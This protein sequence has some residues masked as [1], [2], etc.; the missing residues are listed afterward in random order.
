MSDETIAEVEEPE[1]TETAVDDAVPEKMISASRVE[2]LV[3][4]AKL[5]GRDAMQNEI[6]AVRQQNEELKAQQDQLRNSAQA[7][8]P[9][10]P[11]AIRKQVYDDLVNNL[12]LQQE[13]QK[14]AQMQAEA[15]K[16]SQEYHSRMAT[17]KD[18]F[19][20][21]NDVMAD[22]DPTAFPQLVYLATQ[23]ENT[24]QIMYELSKNPQKLAALAVLSE[25]DPR[26]AKAMMGK[27]SKSIVANQEAQAQEKTAPRPLNRLQS[28]PTGQD[29]GQLE[30]QDFMRMYKG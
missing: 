8:A 27:L 1:V 26:A 18:Q 22:F 15:E 16:I 10:D 6:D 20:D 7:P 13:E 17:G 21:F 29:S 5:K 11:E 28:S 4:K 24:P 2:E 3:K 14:Q 12:Q 9:V 25:R 19:D 30:M 23:T